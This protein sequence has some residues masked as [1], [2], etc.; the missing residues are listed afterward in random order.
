MTTDFIIEKTE[1]YRLITQFST[2][3]ISTLTPE[4]I[5][6]FVSPA[7]KTIL[8][9]EPDDLIGTLAYNLMHSDDIE[10]IGMLHIKMLADKEKTV[11][12]SRMRNK[13]GNY[14][15]LETTSQPILNPE[16]GEIDEIIVVS[17]DI[18]ARVELEKK[19]KA[20]MD[21]VREELELMVEERTKLLQLANG[22]L[23]DE[24]NKRTEIT[25][26]MMQ[27]NKEVTDSIHYA[28]RIQKAVLPKA[29]KFYAMFPKSFI[30]S[31]AKDIVNGDFLWFHTVGNKQIIILSDCSGH[32][33]P[34][35]FMSII[36]NDLLDTIVACEGETNPSHILQKLEERLISSLKNGGSAEDVKD[37]MDIGV[38]VID[39]NTKQ[40]S[41]AG[42]Y[43]PLFVCTPEGN[44]SE[45]QGNPY[46]IG[47]GLNGRKKNFHT[48]TI[49]ITEDTTFYLFSDGYYSQF[50]GS[51]GKKFMKSKF[52]DTIAAV[53][54]QPFETQKET[55]L[56]TLANWQGSN[57]QVDDIL[58]LG[59]RF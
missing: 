3:I 16:T 46:S 36:G 5:Y 12:S 13:A 44:F 50:G 53:S 25:R 39:R 27:K 41:F 43:R 33:V 30:L 45:I 32:G 26:Q 1:R 17:R 2:D 22:A 42:A 21:K 37:G 38:C 49:D 15:W 24:V 28:R 11:F 23:R 52:R 9:Y 10:K 14:I 19:T 59:F 58:V 51:K 6:T 4:G 54:L 8:G 18:T 47:G 20:E 55:L 56:N 48:S 57:E 7:C 35:A 29:E 40:L 34:G 31:K